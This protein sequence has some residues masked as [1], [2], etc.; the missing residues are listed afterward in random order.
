MAKRFNPAG[1]RYAHRGLWTQD[2]SQENS[3]SAFRAAA[4]AGLGIEFDLRPSADGEIMIFH[5]ETLERMTGMQGRFEDCT[6]RELAALP[7]REPIAA[8]EELLEFW[9][10]DLPLLAELKID[11]RT[12][13]VQFARKAGQRLLE[14]QGRGAAMS[15]SETAVNAFPVG[16]M[17]GQLVMPGTGTGDAGLEALG[18]RAI[19]G[20]VDY[21]AVHVSDMERAARLFPEP[22]GSLIV[23][24]VTS[25]EVLSE[26]E[27][28]GIAVI[29]ENIEP[30]RLNEGTRRHAG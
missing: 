30:Y 17:R 13:P 24:T 15:F 20:G 3:L 4:A 10:L 27:A 8:F 22:S 6:A 1:F 11:G 21:L 23:W 5:D 7:G 25:E 28:L 29:L 2:G 14:W 18:R 26:A 9:P 19:A 12:D 16:L